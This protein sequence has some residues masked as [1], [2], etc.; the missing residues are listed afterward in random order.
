MKWMLVFAVLSSAVAQGAG[1]EPSANQA[2]LA[3]VDE[4][5]AKYNQTGPGCAVGVEQEG[6]IL[7]AKGYG[8][9]DLDQGRPITP[10]TRFYMASVSKQFTAMA[11]LLLVEDG[12]LKLDDRV[13]TLIPELP[14]YAG[15]VTVRQ[16]L[17]HTSGLRDFFTLA[18]LSG[19]PDDHS[20][21]EGDVLAILNK[22]AALDFEPGTDFA[23]SNSGYVLLSM[24]VHRVS[25]K[26]L[27]DFARERI[28]L[29][30]RM[31]SSHFQHDHTRAVPDKANGYAK[32]GTT[33]VVSNSNL[34]VVGDGGLYSSLNDMLRWSANMGS[35]KLGA[36][37]LAL[38]SKMAKLKNGSPA[39]YGMGLV[40]STLR[41]LPLVEHSGSLAGYR[42]YNGWFPKQRLGM[43]LLCN[44]SVDPAVIAKVEEVFLEAELSPVPV[45]KFAVGQ[46]AEKYPGLY[47]DE[48]GGYH[49]FAKQEG[50]LVALRPKRELSEIA[51]STFVP[52]NGPEASRFVFAEDGRTLRVEGSMKPPR[53]AERVER[54]DL[55]G[56]AAEAYVGTYSSEEISG[57]LIIKRET[58][59]VLERQGR[60]PL[61][62]VGT[63]PDR[64]WAQQAGLELVVKR[65]PGGQVTGLGLNGG[66]VRGLRYSRV[67]P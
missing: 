25:G 27:D 33:W 60:P 8:V 29:P 19:M 18:A 44:G 2:Q 14:P 30:L 50:K 16:L 36:R 61:K 13:R 41:G 46:A 59:L 35:G 21:T 58:G 48:A 28:F 15:S 34:D 39:G 57:T 54:M 52:I 37:P 24:I 43:V 9:A 17:T 11:T 31:T 67:S 38:M 40:P 23:Y 7:L 64:L 62:L 55:T 1:A 45:P 42:T 20:F 12:R 22:Q 6:R 49:E 51:P 10:E 5:F 63:G 56:E 3:R 4:I 53:R 26:P 66:G 32:S 47:R 65:G